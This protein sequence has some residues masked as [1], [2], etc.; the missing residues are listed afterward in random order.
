MK[1][2]LEDM[3]VIVGIGEAI[4]PLTSPLDNPSSPQALIARAAA[5]ALQ[6]ALPQADLAP[7]IDVLIAVRTFADST[8]HWPTPFGSSS[9][10]PRS[11]AE[12]IG[13]APK[14]A[15]YTEVGGDV[16]QRYVNECCEKLARGDASMILIAGGEAIAN[17][18]AAA[19]AGLALDWAEHPKGGLENRGLGIDGLIAPEAIRHQLFSAPLGYALCEIAR[20]ARQ[21]DSPDAYADAMAELL[22]PLSQ[23]AAG[24]HKAMFPQAFTAQEIKTPTATNAYTA[25]PYTRAMVAK[26]AVNQAAALLLT[27]RSKA[28]AL[29]VAEEKMTYLHA[30]V[31]LNDKSLLEREDLSRSM[32]L[33]TA[34]E[35]LMKRVGS[36]SSKLKYLDIYS[37]FP[38]VLS[39]AKAALDIGQASDMP[40]TQTGGL[41]FFGG[42]GNNYS[43][44]AIASVVRRLR[45]DTASLGLVHANGG[46]MDKHAIG[47]YGCEPGWQVCDSGPAQRALDDKAAQELEPHPR[48]EATIET[49][50]VQFARGQPSYAVVVGRLKQSGRRFIA[51]NCED[52]QDILQRLMASDL[53]GA[54]ILVSS[55]EAGNR[56]RLVDA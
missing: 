2:P 9:N 45:H 47:I 34:Y 39:E 25:Y 52:D 42:P 22:V 4:E 11:I 48:G 6:D 49:Y 7:F 19:K 31:A 53:V 56:V 55:L 50:A 44:H 35:Y 28:L 10:L 20:R 46:Y 32:A 18:K 30:Y 54:D 16:P 36:N 17:T 24:N 15:V 27:T 29:G 26:D 40:L 38:I 5:A 51:N 23:V 12:R 14:R 8:A 21:G 37:C 13:T 43:M 41:P 3:P 1:S 33:E